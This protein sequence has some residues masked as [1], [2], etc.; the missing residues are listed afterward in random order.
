MTKASKTSM[1][2]IL[3]VLI[4]FGMSLYLVGEARGIDQVT[5][6]LTDEEITK[7]AEDLAKNDWV[8]KIMD[9]SKTGGRVNQAYL[10][11]VVEVSDNINTDPINLLT[12]IHFE[13]MGTFRTESHA[14]IRGETYNP[15]ISTSSGAIGF[16]A[17]T[18]NEINNKFGT[19]YT[20][21]DVQ[22]MT[23]Q[24]QLDLA[25]K[26]YSMWDDTIDGLD[27][28]NLETLYLVTIQPASANA[29][30]DVV[31]SEGSN[32]YEGNKKL[33]MDMDGDV[34]KDEIL[35]YLYTNTGSPY[36]NTQTACFLPTTLVT[37]PD[38]STKEIQDIEVGD[39]VLSYDL[40]NK[41]PVVS[42]VVNTYS[43]TT[44]EYL[45]VNDKIRVTP[46]Q[47]VY[48]NG[49]WEPIG[50]AEVGDYLMDK[51]GNK[52]EIQSIEEAYDPEGVM[53]Y[54][55]EVADYHYYFAE[56]VLVHNSEDEKETEYGENP[57][58][59]VYDKS[60]GKIVGY[61]DGNQV[62]DATGKVIGN[63]GADG[64]ITI[65]TQ[66][67]IEDVTTKDNIAVQLT[68]GKVTKIDGEDIPENL[69]SR[70]TYDKE[71]QEL[72]YNAKKVNAGD[73]DITHNVIVFHD[74]DILVVD[75][76][77]DR[78]W[79]GEGSYVIPTQVKSLTKM[80]TS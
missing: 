61:L 67:K 57:D 16:T 64:K 51:D 11:K 25:D 2:I 30:S 56:G 7:K 20:I 38:G 44:D 24:H 80:E 62:K 65:H 33:D 4:V 72:Y 48:L 47:R 21:Y 45:V 13:T 9:S 40:E 1:R 50:N 41:R 22:Q 6:R 27:Y 3:G 55:L 36:F 59:S 52:V 54:D 68:N 69:Q 5:G 60:N 66:T 19:T 58:K 63:K 79:E 31:F 42:G 10:E 53:V 12:V 32:A 73:S 29:Q 43:Y 39:K 15:Q 34:T 18:V 35:Y 28:N 37:L 8:K 74:D 70:F 75:N 77:V 76:D 46:S 17:G 49:E 14:E 26:Y 78:M 23:P 71:T